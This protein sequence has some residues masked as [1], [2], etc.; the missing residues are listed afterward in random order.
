M[1]TGTAAGSGKVLHRR[2]TPADKQ[3]KV[4]G[5]FGLCRKRLPRKERGES[6]LKSINLPQGLL[7]AN[8]VER[9]QQTQ[10]QHPDMQQRYFEVAL[11][12]E[13]KKAEE[14]VND[15]EKTEQ[16]V[17]RKE[18]RSRE[19]SKHS[20]DR[21]TEDGTV[22]ETGSANTPL[23]GETGFTVDVKV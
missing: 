4:E 14:T 6:M 23:E 7:Q 9:I 15:A 8:L 22:D 2:Q 19:E 12:R 5:S 1:A 18:G 17:I 13:K 20:H 16:T 11:A 21:S 10:Q 3:G